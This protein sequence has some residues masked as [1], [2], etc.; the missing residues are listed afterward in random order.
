MTGTNQTRPVFILGTE[1]EASLVEG[2]GHAV[3]SVS[4]MDA[5]DIANT[6]LRL[7]NNGVTPIVMLQSEAAEEFADACRLAG[8]GCHVPSAETLSEFAR[9]VF[10]TPQDVPEFT[11]L[12]EA[13]EAAAVSR[14]EA[15]IREAQEAQMKAAHVYDTMGIAMDIFACECSR[16]PISTGI[17]NL[18]SATGG[19]LPE[20]GLTV[21]GAGSSS[22]KTTLCVQ[23]SDHIAASGRPVLFVTIEQ[24]RH[25]LVAKSI[26]RLMRQTDK[27]N[28]GY[29]VASPSHIMSKKERDNWP[30]EKT[31]ALLACCTN[32]SQT[33]APH[34][35]YFEMDGQPSMQDIRKA[36]EVVCSCDVCTDHEGNVMSP[37]LV[38]DYLQL[39]KAKDE[40]M[41]ERKA[42][43]V[44]V[45]EL[46][47]LAREMKTSVVVI[48]SIN[49]QSYSEGADLSSFKESGGVEFS[50]DLAMVLQ[51]R[52]F[53]DRVGNAKSEKEAREKAREV[54]T[55]HKGKGIRE[56]EL[57][58]LKNRGGAMPNKPVPL[59]F[60]AMCSL[61]TE[62]NAKPG[63]GKLSGSRRAL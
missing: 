20:G 40:R 35:H 51:P 42:V 21:L 18:D 28:G 4:G 55:E 3:M 8:V 16:E 62:D 63:N 19:G 38:V 57:V 61:F 32:Y 50:A 10:Y 30:K 39:M 6:V 27:P 37:V 14:R 54:L 53:N 58:I 12:L 48:S 52:G 23:I 33:I 2:K 11:H 43:D 46:R 31:E 56:S 36:Y 15:L 59:Q 22:G 29:Y 44:N 60:E 45:M 13:E 5:G 41:T 24:S 26:S 9:L 1:Q 34:L 49:R 17:A 25:E 47:Q 7:K